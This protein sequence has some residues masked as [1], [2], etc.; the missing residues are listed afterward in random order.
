MGITTHESRI[1][2]L[3]PL[4]VFSIH[5]RRLE[6]KLTDIEP[7]PDGYKD[8]HPHFLPDLVQES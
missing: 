3:G 2:L 1:R 7:R 6:P 5:H 8:V 4:R